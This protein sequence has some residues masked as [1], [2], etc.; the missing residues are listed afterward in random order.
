VSRRIAPDVVVLDVGEVIVDETRVWTVWAALLGVSPGTLI[1]VLGAAVSQGGD[2]ADAFPHVAPN[3]DWTALEVEHEARYGGFA[4]EDVYAD[5]VPA[6]TAL[7]SSGLRVVLAG[8]QP[9]RRT[10]QLT[11]LGLPVD[12][13]VMSDDLGAEKPDPAFFAALLAHLEIDDASRVLYVGD[14]VDNDVL[15]AR[16]AGMAVCWLT[17]GPWGQLQE[18]PEQIVPDLVLEG[19][20]E[21]PEL[22]AAWQD[23]VTDEPT[24]GTAADGKDAR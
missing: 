21:L 10:P 9:A 19:L 3:V 2:H 24:D 17:R 13:V 1:A 7:Q 11:A 8:N 16:E 15:P 23:G 4:A 12:D 22:L 18:L 20:G 5:V 6:L 14:R